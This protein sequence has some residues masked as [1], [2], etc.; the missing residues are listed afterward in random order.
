MGEI[1][2]LYVI[3]AIVKVGKR[4]LNVSNKKAHTQNEW[5]RIIYN[6]EQRGEPDHLQEK[7]FSKL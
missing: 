1:K 6:G 7:T 5:N 4:H 3:D 2:F